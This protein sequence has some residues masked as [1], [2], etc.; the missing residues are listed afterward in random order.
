MLVGVVTF[1]LIATVVNSTGVTSKRDCTQVQSCLTRGEYSSGPYEIQVG[2]G[3]RPVKVSCDMKT[4]GG[5]WT[6]IQR[7]V[8][9][10]VN[11]YNRTW[12]DYSDGFGNPSGNFWIGLSFLHSILLQGRYVLRIDMEDWEA[13]RRFA[14]YDDFFV[15]DQACKYKLVKI[16]EY[17]GDAGDSLA[18]QLGMKFSTP[19]QDNDALAT[20]VCARTYRGAWWYKDCHSS[21]LNGEYKPTGVITTFADGIDWKEWKGHYYSLKKVEMK[22]RPYTF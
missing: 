21:N 8:D 22:I 20:D 4:D 11:F 15:G 18:P 19:D 7:R 17:C 3:K 9:A 1:L 10:S 16:G 12:D 6:V 13:N 14:Q 5:G 2:D